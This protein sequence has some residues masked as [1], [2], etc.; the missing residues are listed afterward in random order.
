[1]L[2]GPRD[3]LSVIVAIDIEATYALFA[4]FLVVTPAKL[5]VL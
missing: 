1:M 4:G 2:G 5:H 3:Y